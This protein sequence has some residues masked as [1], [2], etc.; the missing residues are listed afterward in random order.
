M[1]VMGFV[2]G[3]AQH[4]AGVFGGHH[5]REG[6]GFGH[7]FFVAA[8]AEGR[9]V[10]EFGFERAGVVGV[11]GLRAVAGFAGDLGVASGGTHGRLIVVAENASGLSGVGDGV[12]AN[13][14]QGAGAVVAV[15][16]EVF[17]DD[18]AADDDEQS[19][20]DQ[21]YDRRL[22]QVSGIANQPLHC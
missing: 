2:A 9:D 21:E 22:N 6:L 20:S 15:L 3:V 7:V 10:G 1:R 16:S 11:F 17:G 5:L 13:G 18:G 14:G 4:A 19:E 8:G 12:F